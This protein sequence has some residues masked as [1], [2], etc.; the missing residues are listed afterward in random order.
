MGPWPHSA[1]Q[2]EPHHTALRARYRSPAPLLPQ[3]AQL[4]LAGRH[5]CACLRLAGAGLLV[6]SSFASRPLGLPRLVPACPPPP[7]G[8]PHPRRA[9]PLGL[10][11]AAW[12]FAPRRCRPDAEGED[13]DVGGGGDRGLMWGGE[14][15]WGIRWQA[16]WAV[17]WAARPISGKNTAIHE[18]FS[19]FSFS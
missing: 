3:A 14:E 15:A 7:A 10:A 6:P 5:R 1:L 19:I 13:V 11:A 8:L 12:L 17:I 4:G 9:A 2:A 16:N 18:I